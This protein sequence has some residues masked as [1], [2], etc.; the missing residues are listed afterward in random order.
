MKTQCPHCKVKFNTNDANAGRQAKCPKCAQPFTIQPVA[1]VPAQAAPT[2]GAKPAPPP[3]AAPP[4][5]PQ[6]AQTPPPAVPPK[7]VQPPQEAPSAPPA[8]KPA[9]PPPAPQKPVEAAAASAVAPRPATVA[10]NPPQAQATMQKP[11][12]AAAQ[13]APLAKAAEP[14]KEEAAPKTLP[15]KTM[16]KLL[17]V[18]GWLAACVI[19]GILAVAGMM[20]ALGQ[21]GNST[22]LA[23]FAAGDVFLLAA[24]A[25]ELLLFYRMW[26]AIPAAQ[27]SI[28]PGKAVGFLFI[29]GFNIYWALLMLTAF[30]ED[31]S[32]RLRR[33]TAQVKELP[34]MLYAAHAFTLLLFAIFLVIP[35]L[36]TLVISHFVNRVFSYLGDLA[37]PV[38]GLTVAIGLAHLVTYLL[39]ANKTCTA[40]N[41]FQGE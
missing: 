3:A 7:N 12:Q 19:T 35:L 14:I 30:T 8:P 15:K 6:P 38:V 31:C 24:V 27:A 1:E 28:S 39:T 21:A 33:S 18:Y 9:Q 23:A 2:L 11:R 22:V 41:A 17:Y 5:T 32:A 10:P 25:I 4:K 16:P 20:L 26:D 34:A 13:Q 37:W 36:C 29:P 40:V